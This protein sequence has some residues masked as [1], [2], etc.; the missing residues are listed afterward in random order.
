MKK[1]IQTKT[2]KKYQALKTT[3]WC[4]YAG[5]YVVPLIPSA[6]LVGINWDNWF[7]Q[8]KWSIGIGFGMLLITILTTIL[9]IAKKDKFLNAKV[10]SLYYL[11]GLMAL[12]GITLLFLASIANQF[13]SMLLYTACG[14]VGGSTCDQINKSY[15][16]KKIDFYKSVLKDSGLYKEDIKKQLAYEKA[17][18]EAKEEKEK[19]GGLI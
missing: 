14:L 5:T 3:K 12:W 1:R 4:L 19:Y 8:D 18:K 17:L 10:S 7:N 13:G 6:V 16:S 2:Q 9:G 11:A 15:V